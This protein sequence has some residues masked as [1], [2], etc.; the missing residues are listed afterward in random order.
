MNRELLEGKKEAHWM[1][2]MKWKEV[3]VCESGVTTY[4]SLWAAGDEA[5]WLQARF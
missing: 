5:S 3:K 2:E 1:K 4:D